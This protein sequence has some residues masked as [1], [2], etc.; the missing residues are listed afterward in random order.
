MLSIFG[1]NKLDIAKTTRTG[2][3]P[4][5][6]T[7]R[8]IALYFGA[9]QVFGASRDDHTTQT[10][11]TVLINTKAGFDQF[12]GLIRQSQQLGIDGLFVSGV[13]GPT[14]RK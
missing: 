2:E 13:P 6:F 8:N 12:F 14:K 1:L 4:P 5:V 9:G 7:R 10:T 11:Q 3:L